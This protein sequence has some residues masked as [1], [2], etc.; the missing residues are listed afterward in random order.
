MTKPDAPRR[1]RLSFVY[2]S[3]GPP[4]STLR[5][6][7]TGVPDLMPGHLRVAMTYAPVNPSDLIPITGAYSH[8][9]A[10]PAVAG[11]EGVGRVVEASP[12][13]SHRV[14]QRVLPLRGE[15]T[16]QTLVDCAGS[17]AVEVPGAVPDA[18][19]ARAYINPLAAFTMLRLWPVRGRSVLLSG[20]GSS[21]ADY[22]GHWALRQGAK[23][24]IGIYRSKSRVPRMRAL[25]IE[26]VSMK[27]ATRIA[28]AAGP[29]DVTFDALGGPV[30]SRILGLM[31]E[32]SSFV[33]YGLLTGEPVS[34]PDV[35]RASFCRFHMRDHLAPGGMANAFAGIWPLLAGMELPPARIF[36][37]RQWREAIAEAARP[38]APKPILDFSQIEG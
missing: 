16:W 12:E 11:Y 23:S 4:L 17:D 29:A 34:P 25:G 27:D 33:G 3:F 35:P 13:L 26:P 18:V 19:A 1:T 9:I 15:G 28:E 7:E 36:P 30:A 38:G 21:C 2:S 32:G 20:A 37:A 6:V 31:P 8:R 24:A 5:L 14:G 10:L 22:L